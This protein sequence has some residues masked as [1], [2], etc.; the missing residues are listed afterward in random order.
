MQHSPGFMALVES[1]KMKIR[2]VGVE[3]VEKK[4]ERGDLF[5]FVDTR[6][7]DEWHK[8]K[9]RGAIHI[10]KGVIERDIEE[11]IP[12]K[13]AEIVL[14]CGGGFRSALA[15]EALMQMG[16]N[17]VFSMAGGIREWQAHDLP[18]EPDDK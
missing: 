14:Y 12:D 9:C 11:K 6:E 13:N 8:G 7:D 4:L 18:I 1:A 16:Y 15:A 17:N 3:E 2:E 5:F 10:G